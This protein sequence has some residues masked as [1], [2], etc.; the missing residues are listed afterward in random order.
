MS[1]VPT[2]LTIAVIFNTSTYDVQKQKYYFGI[3]TLIARCINGF[4]TITRE[5]CDSN[6]EMA[7][8]PTNSIILVILNPIFGNVRLSEA[9]IE[10]CGMRKKAWPLAEIAQHFSIINIHIDLQTSL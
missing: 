1:Q 10:D 2:N 4:L 7:C 5:K 9:E 6:L 3:I 8:V